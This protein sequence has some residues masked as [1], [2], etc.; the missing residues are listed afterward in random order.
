VEI[1]PVVKTR[2]GRDAER[3]RVTGHTV[4]EANVIT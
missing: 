2:L 4:S 3:S 1:P